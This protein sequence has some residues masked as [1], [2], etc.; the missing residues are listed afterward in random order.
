MQFF[1]HTP[2][3][4]LNLP[5]GAMVDD[6]FQAAWR[7]TWDEVQQMIHN[8]RSDYPGANLTITGHSLGAASAV[9]AALALGNDTV[10]TVITCMYQ[11]LMHTSPAPCIASPLFFFLHFSPSLLSCSAFLLS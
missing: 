7:S 6:G 1:W 2:A 5:S 11:C 10:D 4:E 8:A 3:S 9:L